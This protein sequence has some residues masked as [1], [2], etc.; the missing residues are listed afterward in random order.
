[1]S[2]WRTSRAISFKALLDKF[3][4]KTLALEPMHGYGIAVRPEQ[5][6]KGL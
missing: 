6:S 1:M 4:L 5:M 2:L 3:I